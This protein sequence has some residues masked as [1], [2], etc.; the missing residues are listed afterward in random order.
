MSQHVLI[1]DDD[2]GIR[3][4]VTAVLE[5]AGLMADTAANGREALDRIAAHR[6]VV[7]LLDLQMPIMSGW[8]VLA[9]LREAGVTVPVVFMTAGYRARTEAERHGADGYV[10]KPFELTDLL[11]VVERFAPA[12]RD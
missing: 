4:V 1:V 10:A 3:D 9:R 2:P 5:D 12:K 8:E 7:V 11:A 6:P